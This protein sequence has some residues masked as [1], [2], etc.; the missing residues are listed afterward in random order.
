MEVNQL[1]TEKRSELLH[2]FSLNERSNG[3]APQWADVSHAPAWVQQ[4]CLEVRLAQFEKRSV[5]AVAERAYQH[6][7]EVR[8][9]LPRS[10]KPVKTVPPPVLNVDA[11]NRKRLEALGLRIAAEKRRDD[12]RRKM[13][14]TAEE[15]E[16]ER[17]QKQT[18]EQLAEIQKLGREILGEE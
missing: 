2:G 3:K 8:S 6:A 14:P 11:E 13:Y 15:R 1:S 4:R 10:S 18:R 9:L 12:L 7:A 5:S 16:H 17:L